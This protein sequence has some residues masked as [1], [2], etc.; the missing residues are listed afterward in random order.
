MALITT[1][2]SPNWSNC[3]NLLQ[4]IPLLGTKMLPIL[5]VTD[6]REDSSRFH[7]LSLEGGSKSNTSR[8]AKIR[9]ESLN[10]FRR[11]DKNQSKQGNRIKP[12][13]KVLELGAKPKKHKKKLAI[14][15]SS[16]PH[17]SSQFLKA[18][19]SASWGQTANVPAK[20]DHVV[21]NHFDQQRKLVK[22]ISGQNCN[23]KTKKGI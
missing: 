22:E 8:V 20:V 2:G 1:E 23:E 19:A 21:L 13:K 5:L 18:S 9:R 14:I 4:K 3:Y 11:L 6:R 15:S 16:T 10:D 7:S 12:C 17:Y